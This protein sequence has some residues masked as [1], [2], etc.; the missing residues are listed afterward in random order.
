MALHV[1]VLAQESVAIQVLVTLYSPAHVPGVVTSVK[2]TVTLV[3][4][5]SEAVGSTNTG[6]AG[7]L[8][9]VV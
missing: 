8:I 7:Q 1:A 9:G 5:K 3:S 4:H 2:V 6:V